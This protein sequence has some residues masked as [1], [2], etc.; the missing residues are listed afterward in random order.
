MISDG[1]LKRVLPAPA[2]A[3]LGDLLRWLAWALVVA[4]WG[5]FLPAYAG[6]QIPGAGYLL[7]R[8]TKV[9]E[10]DAKAAE[11][12]SGLRAAQLYGSSNYQAYLASLR[13]QAEIEIKKENLEKKLQ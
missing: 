12:E 6:M 8:V 4:I 9:T 10:G 5:A 3:L 1:A 11:Q 7:L 13:K 2:V